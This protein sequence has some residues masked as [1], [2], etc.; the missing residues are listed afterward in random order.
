VRL[1][2]VGALYLIVGAAC[3]LALYRRA[4][5]KDR[6]AIVTALTA[7]PLWP[8]WAPVAWTARRA[9]PALNGSATDDL[10]RIRT[11]L[12]EGVEAVAGSP[13]ERLLNRDS[14]NDIVREVERVS[15]RHHEL[16]GLLARPDFDQEIAEHRLLALEKENAPPR[17]RASARLHLENVRRL[18]HMADRDARALQELAALVAALRT[19][20]VLVRLAGSSAEGV[21]DIIAELWTRIETLSETSDEAGASRVELT[22]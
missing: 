1:L 11:A 14:A 6:A 10:S 8:L 20:L 9:P 12:D 18:H 7:I 4:V 5:P 22:A 19:Q 21:G 2:D 15:L 16:L 13:L 3:A 17:V